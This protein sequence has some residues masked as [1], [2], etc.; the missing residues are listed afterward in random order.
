MINS[1]I[2][3]FLF[4]EEDIIYLRDKGL[5][6]TEGNQIVGEYKVPCYKFFNMNEI[7]VFDTL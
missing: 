5:Q 1:I 7:E 4:N 3:K 6:I 2:P